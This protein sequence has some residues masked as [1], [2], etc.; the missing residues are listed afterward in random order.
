MFYIGCRDCGYCREL[1]T[2]MADFLNNYQDKNQNRDL[3]YKIEAGYTCVPEVGSEQREGYEKIYQFLVD[4]K[5]VEANDQK[6][7][8]TPQFIYVE[9][10]KVKGELGERSVAGL[11][12]FFKDH[13]YR[14]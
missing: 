6:G 9:G 1:E 8:G 4:N 11:E 3:I 7:F 14:I 13:K 2:T 10:G 5:I 12:K